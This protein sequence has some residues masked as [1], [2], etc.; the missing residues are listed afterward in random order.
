MLK[1]GT[2]LLPVLLSTLVLNVAGQMPASSSQS[3]KD[4]SSQPAG[5]ASELPSNT[6]TYVVPDATLLHIRLRQTISTFGSRQD[7][8]IT[9]TLIQPVRVQEKIILPLNAEFQ[10]TIA[11]VRRIGVGFSHETALLNLQ[12][13]T[14]V[15]AGRQSTTPER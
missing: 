2:C 5:Q 9:A 7:T 13:D 12:F 6:G 8:P 3:Q 11:R 15:F 14:I 10:G 4:S 1:F